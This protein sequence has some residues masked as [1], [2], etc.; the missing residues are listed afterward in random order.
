MQSVLSS[1]DAWYIHVQQHKTRIKEQQEQMEQKRKAA[2]ARHSQLQHFILRLSRTRLY[3]FY[4]TWSWYTK[5]KKRKKNVL[6]RAV[7]KL[8]QKT[9]FS[10]L[11][12]W[13]FQTN[14]AKC[15]RNLLK[16]ILFKW[17]RNMI[18]SGF[19]TWRS[20]C[21]ISLTVYER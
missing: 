16:K 2:Y 19:T 13:I 20:N 5:E 14:A 4:N 8:K 12:T 11:N 6:K 21:N 15:A 1:F 17:K 3:S 10:S 9:M 7:I 18:Y